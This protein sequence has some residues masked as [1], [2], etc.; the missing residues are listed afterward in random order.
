MSPLLFEIEWKNDNL[1]FAKSFFNAIRN[2][3]F[4]KYFK[5]VTKFNSVITDYHT[6]H[7]PHEAEDNGDQPF[8]GVMSTFQDEEIILD[9]DE[10]KK[11]T[12]EA[13]Q[14]YAALH[15]EE[16]EEILK[17]IND[18]RDAVYIKSEPI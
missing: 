6:C 2:F 3:K 7:F 15:P 18:F 4:T 17:I 11:I 16:A 12:I 5:Q 14:K 13:G 8:N 10:F 1:A 9:F